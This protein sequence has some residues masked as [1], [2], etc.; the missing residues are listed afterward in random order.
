MSKELSAAD[1]AKLADA[2][3]A[4]TLRRGSGQAP[5]IK[6]SASPTPSINSGRSLGVRRQP[7]TG[8]GG[9]GLY[10]PLRNGE[11]MIRPNELTIVLPTY[12]NKATCDCG[13]LIFYAFA[14]Y[15]HPLTENKITDCPH[16]NQELSMMTTRPVRERVTQ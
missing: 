9:D 14:G 5:E 10:G 12:V 2:M 7:R 1:L 3:K 8:R 13:Q 16:C 6:E 15:Y 11:E 4:A